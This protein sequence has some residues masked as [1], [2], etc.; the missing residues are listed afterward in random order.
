MN[1]FKSLII[2]LSMGSALS[3]CAAHSPASAPAGRPKLVI[4]I[5][6]DQ[7]R[8]DY[9]ELLTPQMSTGG[10]ARL[11]ST[12]SY[13]RNVQYAP[14]RLDAASSTA[15]LFTGA[16]PDC[17][18]VAAANTWSP[19]AL[20]LTPS[21]ADTEVIGNFTNEAYSPK[22]LRLSTLTDE[23]MIDGAGLGQAWSVAIDPQMAIIMASHAGTGAVWLDKNSGKWCSSTYYKELPQSASERNYRRPLSSAIDTMQW[24]PLLPLEKYPGL[25]AQKRYYPFRHTFPSS[26]KDVYERFAAS[27]KAN[28]EVA[29]LGVEMLSSMK[30]GNRGDAIDMLCLGFSLAPFKYVKDGDYRLELEDAYLRLDRDIERLLNAADKSAGLDNTL[31][32]VMSTGYYDDATIDDEKYKIP[33]GTFSVKRALSLLNAFLTARHGQGNYVSAWSNGT[34]WLNHSLLESRALSP[35]EVSREVKE[36]LAKMSGVEAVYTMSDLLSST[37]AT[38]EALR[39]STNPQSGADLLVEITPGWLLSDDTGYP[40]VTRPVRRSRY[41]TPAFLSG[42]GL[43][44][45]YEKSDPVP[46]TSIIPTAAGALH[47]RQPNG[48]ISAPLVL[49]RN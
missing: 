15:M 39:L 26:A 1:L 42:P 48:T 44:K 18:G 29:T 2:A 24:K 5:V 3:V 32:I 45:A 8:T 19:S 13:L 35:E 25:P 22:N 30:L 41:P 31:I 10:F 37:S 28:S 9:L 21:L 27:P 47:I 14:S 6:V 11:A 38:E 46:S 23:V 4:A 16:T 20:K 40:T 33:S 34:I 49:P 17:T 43:P 12:G 7:M 36:F